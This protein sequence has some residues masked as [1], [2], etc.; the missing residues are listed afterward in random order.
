M[1][2]DPTNND[3][4][5]ILLSTYNGEQYLEMQLDSLRDQS[6]KNFEV[7]ARDDGST[8]KSREILTRY[9]ITVIS[10]DANVGIEGSFGLLLEHTLKHTDCRYFMFCDQ[11]D[12]WQ[13]NKIEQT[14]IKMKKM[15]SSDGNIPLLVHTDLEVVDE[16]LKMIAPSFLQYQHLDHNKNSF[17]RLLLQNTITGC[18]MM[19][20]RSLAEKALPLPENVMMHDWWMGLVA[21]CFGKIGFIDEQTILY[22]QHDNNS[23]GAQRPSFVEA[24]FKSGYFARQRSLLDQC[25]RQADTFLKS[26]EKSLDAEAVEILLAFSHI[27]DF[28]YLK[29][30]WILWR[31]AL[32][33][34]GWLRNIALFLII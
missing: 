19:I 6:Y 10:S 2:I 3:R 13:R 17:N 20:N 31:Y 12:V 28:S 25:S 29:R 9:G 22:R 1:P 21:S 33:K 30:R 7:V 14:L 16:N 8:D 34:Q 18:T 24:I 4:V 11:D 23:I 32:F 26:Y 27:K 5:L 15:E